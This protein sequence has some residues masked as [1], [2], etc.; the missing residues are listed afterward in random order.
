MGEGSYQTKVKRNTKRKT[1]RRIPDFLVA[2]QDAFDK[3]RDDLADES[4]IPR[5]DARDKRDN[6]EVEDKDNLVAYGY[7][8]HNHVAQSTEFPQ[9]MYNGYFPK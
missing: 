3:H 7:R 1:A 9:I 2:N 6:A 5:N 8:L 4:Q